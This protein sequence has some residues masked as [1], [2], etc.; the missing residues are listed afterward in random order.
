MAEFNPIEAHNDFTRT[1]PA[2][3]ATY[4]NKLRHILSHITLGTPAP[5]TYA[6]EKRYPDGQKWREA[7]DTAIRNLEH[8]KVI[9]WPTSPPSS[10][11]LCPSQYS[12]LISGTG[13]ALQA[14]EKHVALYVVT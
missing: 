8:E 6:Q 13:M 11:K 4:R 3:Y 10:A 5:I 9:E 1:I 2:A 14:K 7:Y 12:L